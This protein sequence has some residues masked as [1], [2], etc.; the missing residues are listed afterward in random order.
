MMSRKV[1]FQ[2]LAF[3]FRAIDADKNSD[4]NDKVGSRNLRSYCGIRPCQN[5]PKCSAAL[6]EFSLRP[7]YA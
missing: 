3:M 7:E 6:G 4:E 2:S 5:L 1:D